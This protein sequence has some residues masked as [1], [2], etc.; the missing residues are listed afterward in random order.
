MV[1]CDWGDESNNTVM[2]Y[3][4]A[5]RQSVASHLY[6]GQGTFKPSVTIYNYI[7]DCSRQTLSKNPSNEE[8]S[9]TIIRAVRGLRL[10]QNNLLGIRSQDIQIDI[11]L[12]AGTWVN[13]TV[14]WN[15]TTTDSGYFE[16]VL[17]G[18]GVV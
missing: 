5:A 2:E 4:N 14:D 16:F 1:E 10:S 7:I 11:L 13:I 15:D 12:D 18:G 8:W 6:S 17:D 9:I 3:T